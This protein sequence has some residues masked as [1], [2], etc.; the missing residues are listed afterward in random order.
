VRNQGGFVAAQ[1]SGFGVNEALRY[2]FPS[3]L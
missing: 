3:L 1:D 2:F